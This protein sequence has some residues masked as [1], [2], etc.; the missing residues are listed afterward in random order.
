MSIYIKDVFLPRSTRRA[1]KKVLKNHKI[2]RVLRELR[3]LNH[4]T[5]YNSKFGLI[6]RGADVNSKN[7]YGWTPLKFAYEQ[8]NFKFYNLLKENGAIK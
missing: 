7:S 8:T 6:E 4:S 2:L 5:N 1:R 3:G